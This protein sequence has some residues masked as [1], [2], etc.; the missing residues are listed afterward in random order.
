MM[1]LLPWLSFGLLG[2]YHGLNPGM[3]WLFAVALGLQERR[4]RAVLRAFGPIAAGHAASVTVVVLLLG[5]AQLW[6]DAGLLQLFGGAALVAFGL[7]KL[8][9]PFSHP[10]WVGLRVGPADLA[11][12]SFLMASAH[13]AGLMLMPVLLGLGADSAAHTAHAAGGTVPATV[14]GF[15]GLALVNVLAVGVHTAAMFLVMAA[16]AL[17]VYEKLGLKILRTAWINLDRIWAGTL[18]VTGAVTLVL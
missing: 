4:R 17:V 6:V 15:G 9:R 8:L 1:D 3:G 14:D 7:Y 12:W 11:L 5:A 13:G 16:I 18:I 10:K 2:A